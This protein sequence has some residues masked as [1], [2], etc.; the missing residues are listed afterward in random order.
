MDALQHNEMWELISLPP[1]EKTVSSKW[2]FSIK[3]LTGGS[4]DQYKARLVA[5]G[6]TQ[7][8]GKDFNDTFVPVAKLTSVRLFVSLATSHNWPLHQLDVKNDFL[9]CDLLETIYM[10]PPPGFWVEGKYAGKVG[11]S[12]FSD[13]NYA[14]SKTDRRLTSGFY[15]VLH[16]RTKHIEVDIHFIKEKVRLGIIKSCFVRSS[17]QSADVFTKSVGSSLLH[18]SFTK[19]DLIDISTP[20]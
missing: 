12:C 17:N 14:G 2:V 20:A 8:P 1:G 13:A 7:I 19:L 6:F 3:Y 18:S 4:I 11:L 9:N 5:K 15:S 10:D 16:E